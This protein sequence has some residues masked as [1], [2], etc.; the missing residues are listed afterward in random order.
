MPSEMC[1]KC[2]KRESCSI[3]TRE[4]AIQAK[5]KEAIEQAAINEPYDAEAFNKLFKT[6]E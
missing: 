1:E 4:I 5:E 3:Y 2:H 6:E